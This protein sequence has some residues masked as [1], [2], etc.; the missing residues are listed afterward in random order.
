MNHGGRSTIVKFT[1]FVVVMAVL[2]GFLY[3]TFGQYRTGSTN[4]Y[5]AV[6]KDVSKLKVGDTVRVAGVRVGTVNDVALQSD[7]N[8][9]V[10]FDADPD[11]VLTTGTKLAVRYLNL[12]GDRYLDLV[13]GPGSTHVLPV[14]AQIPSDRT[15]SALD[16]DLLLNGL[17]PVVRGLNPQ[18]V[19]ALTTSLV[20]VLQGQGD[21]LDSLLSK[22]SSFSSTIAD[23]GQTVEQLIDNLDA[24]VATI[25]KDGDKFSGAVDRIE[26]LVTGLSADRDPIGTAIDS[27]STGTASLADLLGNL[28]SPL[29]GT[30]DQ[31]N[32]VAPNLDEQKA[33][34]DDALKRAPENYRKLIRVGS[35][36]SFINF[37]VCGLRF[38]VTDLQGRTAVFPW[39]KQTTGRCAEPDA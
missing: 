29:T 18:D 28:R 23:N 16:L 4:G 30:I 10:K 33:Y 25:S 14:G 35:Y 39:I 12:V 21:N 31:L 13:D 7:D 6:F 27:L 32:R 20:Q 11:V 9:L 1:A 38:R 8:V 19:N 3:M 17:K 24:V 37:Y 15:Q 36:G 5:S 26:K 2:T 34:L 22:T